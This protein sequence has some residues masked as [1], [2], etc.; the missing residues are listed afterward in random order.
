[1]FRS[2]TSWPWHN[3]VLQDTGVDKNQVDN[4]GI[5]TG[6]INFSEEEN[7][8]WKYFVIAQD[9]N[10]AT[11]D[12]EPEEAAQII[13]GM[14]ST[15]QLSITFEGGNCPIAYDGEGEVEVR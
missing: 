7:G 4:D 10:H 2:W 13:G 12:M 11:P 1:M 14:V 8:T 9:I 3:I 6:T 5:Y 15:N